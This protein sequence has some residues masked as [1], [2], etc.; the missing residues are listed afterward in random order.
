M[1]CGG[2]V[3]GTSNRSGI[4]WSLFSV[5][6]LKSTDLNGQTHIRNQGH[7]G[8]RHDYDVGIGAI[9]NCRTHDLD[10]VEWPTDAEVRA[11][12]EE[13]GTKLSCSENEP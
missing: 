2:L 3:L 8:L 5:N 9:R 10:A 12:V 11:A 6:F 1:C 13:G 4:I 7:D